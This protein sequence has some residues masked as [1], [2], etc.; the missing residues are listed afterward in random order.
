MEEELSRGYGKR[1]LH[2]NGTRNSEDGETDEGRKN[3]K[4]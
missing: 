4:L 3:K 2:A 1:K